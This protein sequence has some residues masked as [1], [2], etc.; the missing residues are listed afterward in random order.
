MHACFEAK[1]FFCRSDTLF[2]TIREAD[3]GLLGLYKIE[4]EKTDMRTVRYLN[5]LSDYLFTLSR[6]YALRLGVTELEWK[7]LS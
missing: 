5:R 7:G 4:V 1:H 6:I 3:D 2:H